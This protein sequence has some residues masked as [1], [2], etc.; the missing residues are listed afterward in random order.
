MSL[1]LITTDIYKSYNGNEVLRDCSFSFEKSGIYVLTGHN[2]CGKSTFLRIC[3]F[4]EQPDSGEVQYISNDEPT[5]KD[6][7]LRRRIT[8]VLPRAGI[9]NTTVF[10][11][12]AYG[13]KIRGIRGSEARQRVERVLDFVGLGQKKDQ[14]ALTVSSGEAQ[15]LGIARALVIEPEILF[16]DEPTASVDQKNTGIIEEIIRRMKEE[17][18]VTIIMTTHDREQA[19]RIADHLLVMKDGKI[20]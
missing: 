4:V 2:G 6:L 17:R 15:R 5:L 13:L 19:S 18:K 10:N 16:L 3:A 8:L 14:N 7:S 12:A 11:N 1:R 20:N 9:F